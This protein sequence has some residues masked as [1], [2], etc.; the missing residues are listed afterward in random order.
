[1]V[2]I[3]VS[4]NF[5]SP[6]L[7]KQILV[8]INFDSPKLGKQLKQNKENFR[9]LIH[10]YAQFCCFRKWPGISFSTIFCI[11]FFKKNLSYIILYWLS[12]FHCLIGFTSWDTD[13]Y[14]CLNCLL[15]RLWHIDFEINLIFPIK[16]F[17]NMIKK[18]R[19]RFI[20]LESEKSF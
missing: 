20:H 5:D 18:S 8:S 9:I 6:K 14:V 13:K 12:K 1:M 17:S 2:C 3:L 7:G 4:I 10:R 11:W 15:T 16:P 19:E